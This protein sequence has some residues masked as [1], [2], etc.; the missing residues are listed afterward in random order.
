MKKQSKNA[1]FVNVVKN[2]PYLV[3]GEVPIR[4]VYLT[5]DAQNEITG[6][7]EGVDKSVAE[8]CVALCRCG[9][10]CNKPFCDGAHAEKAVSA[11]KEHQ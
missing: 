7:Q 8:K 9:R 1:V 5:P 3:H 6:Y 2:G 10:S 4:E 11:D